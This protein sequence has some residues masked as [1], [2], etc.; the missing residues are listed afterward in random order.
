[1]KWP[2]MTALMLTTA[3]FVGCNR[4]VPPEAVQVLK[5]GERVN[6]EQNLTV[7]VVFIGYK[8][9]KGVAEV[10][11]QSFVNRLP[12]AYRA[13]E[14]IPQ[15]YPSDTTSFAG[16]DFSYSYTTKF[17]DKAFEDKFFA[18][19]S[20]IGVKKDLT[21]F[22]SA[23]N[24]QYIPD[25]QNPPCEEPAANLKAPIPAD[26]DNYWISAVETE[27]WLAQNAK[28]LGVDTSKY[29]IFFINWYG[30]PDFKYHTYVKTDE[31]D[32][33][34]NYNFGEIRSSRKMTSWGG[35][36]VDTDPDGGLGGTHRI[37]FNDL[38]AGPTNHTFDISSYDVDGDN[39]VDYRIP[40][41][42]EYGNNKGGYRPFNDLS[43]DLAKI[44]RSVAIN[45]L[46]TPSPIYPVKFT[47][48]KQPKSID[49]KVS[50]YQGESGV[51]GKAFFDTAEALKRWRSLMPNNTISATVI[52]KPYTQNAQGFYE[53][54]ATRKTC[55]NG[56]PGGFGLFNYNFFRLPEVL[57]NN[58]DYEVPAMLYA[59]PTKEGVDIP[60]LGLADDDF[61]TGTQ[62]MTYS[63][64]DAGARGAGYGLTTTTIHEVGHHVGLSHPHDGYDY[65]SG[66]DYGPGGD[67]YFAWLGDESNSVMSYIDLT[68][69]FGQFNLDT[70]HRLSTVNYLNQ[71]NTYLKAIADKNSSTT[72]PA[73]IDADRFAR[74]ALSEYQKMNYASAS[75]S[76]QTA[77]DKVRAVATGL[78]VNLTG[79][80]WKQGLEGQL[81]PAPASASG[82]D[83][84]GGLKAA[85][86][87]RQNPGYFTKR[88]EYFQRDA[89]NRL[90]TRLAP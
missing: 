62:S 60:F 76:A 33:D 11:T 64:M 14:R 90:R 9:G 43:G 27:K 35:T 53:C 22:Q 72:T 86:M 20:S 83:L 73:I 21:L 17:A 75:S 88:N 51:D 74:L 25:A 63:L 79:F 7:N 46:F 24:C 45:L 18:K 28:D 89:R 77:Y 19:L 81:P 31:P 80:D 44:A 65:E 48:P 40:P 13:I 36:A 49:V 1:M 6:I 66:R 70:M 69:E 38:S 39:S 58:A 32:P 37:W 55:P 87:Y 57:N 82:Q 29:T 12:R 30:R 59:L 3:V 47:S 54:Y 61:L 67:T 50:L 34:T 23:F 16:T 41:V 85:E 78:G 42:W 10:D 71:A 26:S 84:P 15:F 68:S 4:S 56:M 8:P 5:A 52:E 2:L